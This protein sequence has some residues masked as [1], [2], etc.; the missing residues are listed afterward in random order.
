MADLD[1]R[2]FTTA[3]ARVDWRSAAIAGL[4]AGL[5]YLLWVMILMPT[6]GDAPSPW[7]PARM[8]AAIA[9]GPGVLPPPATFDAGIVVAAL[10]V[11]FALSVLYALL[12]APVITG[13]TRIPTI[14]AGAVLGITIY[15]INFYLFTLV[16]PWFEEGRGW[17]G[18]VGHTLFGVVLALT[19]LA[20]ARRSPAPGAAVPTGPGARA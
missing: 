6:L 3:G 1:V 7:A 4:V 8:I 18:S 14:V 17:I 12:I 10:A 11:H 2:K 5:F 16:F 9:L 13:M 15:I 20:I 19:Y